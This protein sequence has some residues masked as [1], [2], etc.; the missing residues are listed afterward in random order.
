MD[1]GQPN[2]RFYQLQIRSS[3]SLN[4]SFCPG[5]GLV[6]SRN[7]IQ[8]DLQHSLKRAK[9]GGYSAALIPCNVLDDEDLPLMIE[10]IRSF[11]LQPILQINSRQ[12]LSSKIR[13]DE[14]LAQTVGVQVILGNNTTI[15]DAIWSNLKSK[16]EPFFVTI[17]VHKRMHAQ[18]AFRSLPDWVKRVA[19]FLFPYQMDDADEFFTPDSIYEFLKRFKIQFSGYRALPPPG[20]DIYDRTTPVGLDLELGNGAFYVSELALKSTEAPLYSVI[21]PTQNNVHALL[22]TLQALSKQTLG[23]EKIEIVIVDQGSEAE[24]LKQLITNLDSS[25]TPLRAQVIRMTLSQTEATSLNLALNLGVKNSSGEHVLFLNDDSLFSPDFLSQL[26]ADHSKGDLVQAKRLLLPA[27]STLDISNGWDESYCQAHAVPENAFWAQFYKSDI[28]WNFLSDGWRYITTHQL[29]VRRD[30]FE[31]V[32]WFRKSF[33][34]TGFEDCDF[35]YRARKKGF[36]YFLSSATT[37]QKSA[38]KDMSH[39]KKLQKV[40]TNRQEKS[41]KV[42]FQ[43][44]LDTEIYEQL[45]SFL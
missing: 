24:S 42:F 44:N 3:C 18:E 39:F 14:I 37:Y 40:L 16:S 10:T 36:E 26:L 23:R 12:L 19:H 9:T 11:G 32:G 41:A 5:L 2:S 7:Q 17:V 28:N 8:Q 15:P 13:I 21:I 27:D 45:Q 6:S 31:Y 29:S 20:I 30:V 22:S 33:L 43:N 25:D 35:A 34:L 38:A 4:C 1:A